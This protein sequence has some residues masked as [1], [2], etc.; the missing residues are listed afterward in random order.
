MPLYE[1]EC[2]KCCRKF[3]KYYPLPN[4]GTVEVCPRCG[5]LGDKLYSVCR[6]KIFEVFTTKNILPDGEEV[7]V[8]GEG[9][10]RQLEREHRVRLADRDQPPPQTSFP[11]PT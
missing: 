9:Q 10:L 5:D 3:E 11:E 7:T 8:R 2:R 6:A 1:F 4:D